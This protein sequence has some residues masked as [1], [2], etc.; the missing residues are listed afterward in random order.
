MT[1]GLIV[2]LLL[3]SIVVGVGAADC[4]R[5]RRSDVDRRFSTFQ[6][7]MREKPGG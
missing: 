6:R 5:V 7:A 2:L 3:F 4:V 1:I